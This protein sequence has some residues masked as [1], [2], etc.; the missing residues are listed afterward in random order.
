MPIHDYADIDINGKDI[1]DILELTPS[2]KIKMITEDI[3]EAI[4]NKKL[5]NNK[6][7]ITK[8]LINNK[9]KWLYEK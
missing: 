3:K 8:Y 9:E 7:D 5:K 4:L 6:K 2:I 1:I